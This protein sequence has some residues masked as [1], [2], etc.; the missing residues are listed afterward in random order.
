M[1]FSLIIGCGGAGIAAMGEAVRLL[2]VRP[3]G[4]EGV[5]CLAVDGEWGDL[6]SVASWG[7]K[8]REEESGQLLVRAMR[9]ERADLEELEGAFRGASKEGRGRLAE[10]W[11]TDGEGLPFSGDGRSAVEVYGASKEFSR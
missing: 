7:R 3:G 6:E 2:A 8:M 9:I 11:W 1:N 4:L 10:N 5:A